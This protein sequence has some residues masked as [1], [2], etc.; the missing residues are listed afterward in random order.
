MARGVLTWRTIASKLR[1]V[2]ARRGATCPSAQGPWQKLQPIS[3]NRSLPGSVLVGVAVGER[4]G[5]LS[6]DGRTE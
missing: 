2:P 3:W 4:V 5:A 1:A 6:G